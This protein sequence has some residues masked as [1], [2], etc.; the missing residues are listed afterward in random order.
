MD[1]LLIRISPGLLV[2]VAILT[3][4]L[5]VT[6]ATAAA[7]GEGCTYIIDQPPYSYLGQ[8]KQTGLLYELLGQMAMRAGMSS[9]IS[10]MPFKR[11]AM[12]VKARP[13]S[14]GVIWRQPEIEQSYTWVLKLFEEP[15]IL[16]ARYDT[17]VDIFSIEVARNLRVGVVLGSPA[18]V[19]AR[20]LGFQ[21]IDVSN[22]VTDNAWKLQHGRIDAWL[23]LPS[24]ISA[25]QRQIGSDLSAVRFGLPIENTSM[26]L[27][28]AAACKDV[29]INRW[30]EAALA[31]KKDGTYARIVDKYAMKISTQN[32]G[33]FIA[34]K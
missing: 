26:Y 10:S 11:V 8:G 1:H 5:V 34:P 25:A 21:H 7:L 4:S 29:D 27:S 16:V 22:T 15:V 20:R 24:V 17:D 3:T 30:K 19:V 13:N 12:Q 18:E 14:L 32:G 33:D 23:A 28:C 31:M 9:C 2:C 6:T